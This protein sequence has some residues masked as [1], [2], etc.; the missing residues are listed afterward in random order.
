MMQAAACNFSHSI[1]YSIMY[2]PHKRYDYVKIIMLTVVGKSIPFLFDQ[3][4][5]KNVAKCGKIV[6]KDSFHLVLKLWF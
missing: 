2:V 5:G 6:V 4:D 3:I 1:I